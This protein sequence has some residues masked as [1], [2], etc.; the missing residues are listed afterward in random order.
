[1]S[2]CDK[3][4]EANLYPLSWQTPNVSE[5]MNSDLAFSRLLRGSLG[6]EA[7]TE[8]GLNMVHLP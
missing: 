2:L 4:N 8:D 3:E 7:C 1:M 5:E 6:V